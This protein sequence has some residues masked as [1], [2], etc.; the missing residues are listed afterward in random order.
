MHRRSY[1]A[2]FTEVNVDSAGV[3]HSVTTHLRDWLL[4]SYEL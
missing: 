2:S 1:R 4:F 3:H